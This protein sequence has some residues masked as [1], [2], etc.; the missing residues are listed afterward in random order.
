MS[1]N[2]NM[3][4][5]FMRMRYQ[6]SGRSHQMDSRLGQKSRSRRNTWAAWLLTLLSFLVYMAV[7]DW[8]G[9]GQVIA[10][11]AGQTNVVAWL[12]VLEIIAT[13]LFALGIFVVEYAFL[14]RPWRW[15]A[16][17]DALT[18]LLNQGAFWATAQNLWHR[19]RDK[20]SVTIMIADVDHFKSINDEYGH[21]QGDQ[22]LM[23]I[24][25]VLGQPGSSTAVVGRIGGEEFAALWVGSPSNDVY[26]T[27]EH[28]SGQIQSIECPEGIS[29]VTISVGI[30]TAHPSAVETL[31]SLES[32]AR[33]ADKA[34]YRA[35]T[36]GRN[37]IETIQC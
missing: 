4:N 30:A 11:R 7:S 3:M 1:N 12:T 19:Y 9:R 27:A 29:H 32:L 26:R 37:R 21:L 35:K 36:N 13:V 5:R 23:H 14:V 2:Y 34:L 33:H 31:Q 8:T 18:S 24:G 15:S 22:V 10:H 25:H 20:T 6:D 28:W 17:H 16:Q